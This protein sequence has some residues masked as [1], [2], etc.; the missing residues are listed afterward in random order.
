MGEGSAKSVQ[1]VSPNRPKSIRWTMGP[2]A[3][4]HVTRYPLWLSLKLFRDGKKVGE[5]RTGVMWGNKFEEEL[6]RVTE[7]GYD[8]DHQA[9]GFNSS[10][11]RSVIVLGCG[12]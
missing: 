3:K 5:Y 2:S 11:R 9:S 8:S 1:L 7:S 12:K 10:S 6:N 4:G